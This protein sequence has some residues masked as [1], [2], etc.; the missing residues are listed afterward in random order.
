MSELTYFPTPYPDE[1]WYSVLCRYYVRSGYP[2]LQT[3]YWELFRQKHVFVSLYFINAGF[4]GLFERLPQGLFEP[5]DIIYQNS[6]FPY[7]ARFAAPELSEKILN[8]FMEGENTSLSGQ[9][10]Q[11]EPDMPALRY[12]P[13]CAKEDQE[14]YGEL[15]WHNS[16]QIQ[17][18]PLCP[19]H[20]CTLISAVPKKIAYERLIAATSK[21]CKE[22]TPYFGVNR[23]EVEL[24]KMIYVF[25]QDPQ[26]PVT[27]GRKAM[28]NR[29]YDLG[30]LSVTSNKITGERIWEEMKEFYGEK[31]LSQIFHKKWFNTILYRM[32]V[33]GTCSSPEKYALLGTFLKMNPHVITGNEAADCSRIE[34]EMRRLS[35]T[36]FILSK[37]KVA[38]QL[39]VKSHQLD[40]LAKRF[41]IASFWTQ[42]AKGENTVPGRHRTPQTCI[43]AYVTKEEKALYE[44]RVQEIGV[45]SLSEYIRYCIQ[46]EINEERNI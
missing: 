28:L 31:F 46:R 1:N 13:L 8:Y 44:K 38:E 2:K 32:L 23:W 25:L 36:K 19:F 30:F 40:E 21:N 37:K 45:S 29:L 12:C 42:T 7:W 27:L 6:L 9:L 24:T 3:V 26:K 20:F 14:K 4:Y 39:G 17:L 33:S 16:H 43:K 22:Q 35:K 18:M 34:K 11:W 10:K 5:R 41:E 15:Y